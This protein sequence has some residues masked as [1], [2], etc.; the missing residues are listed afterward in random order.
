MTG[1]ALILTASAA[2]VFAGYQTMGTTISTLR[3][4]STFCS[5]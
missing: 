5:N 4:M 1:G 2:V 3:A